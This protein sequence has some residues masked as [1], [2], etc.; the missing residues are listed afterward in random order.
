MEFIAIDKIEKPPILAVLNKKMFRFSA[1]IS[2]GLIKKL[3][4]ES[5]ESLLNENLSLD[6]YGKDFICIGF[7]FIVT[8]LSSEFYPAS[9]FFSKSS[10]KLKL[11]LALDYLRFSQASPQEAKQMMA[12]LYLEAIKTYPS[13]RG[14]KKVKFDHQKFYAD[15]KALFERQGWVAAA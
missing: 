8:P 9:S 6:G 3:D 5:L 12:N 7:V 1:I 2:E 10:Q 13:I 4:I 15:V 11:E 14:M